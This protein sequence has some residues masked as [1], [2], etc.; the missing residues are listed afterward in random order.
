MS[1][2][3]RA[4]RA[5]HDEVVDI[6]GYYTQVNGA[7]D[8]WLR[9]LNGQLT[10]STT[11]NNTM[12]FG[13]DDPGKPDSTYQYRRTFGELIAA[14]AENGTT[15]VIHRRSVVV[16]LVASWEDCHRELIASEC[17]LKKNDMK[18]DVFHDLNR[19]RQA[20]LH[21]G[22]LLREDAKKISF[23]RKGE[24]V[25]LSVGQMDLIFRMI[26]DDL[27]RLGVE[28]YGVNPGFTF[29]KKMAA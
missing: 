18:S 17:G 9:F 19:Y 23:F 21:G 4:L 6:Y 22:G 25:D 20:I 11:P 29:D 15:S 28:H 14:A 2:P 12:F 16:L 3:T 24:R 13:K 7:L 26:V 8:M 1:V 27:N 5:F 10:G